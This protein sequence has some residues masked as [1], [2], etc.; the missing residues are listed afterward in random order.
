MHADVASPNS[1]VKS[2]SGLVCANCLVSRRGKEWGAR[3]VIVLGL[4]RLYNQCGYGHRRTTV[5]Y[6]CYGAMAYE[7]MGVTV[8]VVCKW[9]R[10]TYLEKIDFYR[11]VRRL[12]NMHP[13]GTCTAQLHLD[14]VREV[15]QSV[16]NNACEGQG[17][18][19][20]NQDRTH[21]YLDT[22][23]RGGGDRASRVWG[24]GED[25]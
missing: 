11:T 25:G 10:T 1:F 9:R 17:G 14:G 15:L 24:G 13:R 6:D 3:H 5:H 16:R 21:A 8:T 23:G 4:T 12:D 20:H 22:C 19:T 7:Y 2:D 18:T